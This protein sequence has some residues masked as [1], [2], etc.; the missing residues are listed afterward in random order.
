MLQVD[1]TSAAS[2]AI[3][4]WVVCMVPTVLVGFVCMALG[5]VSFADVRRR[6]SEAE[7]AEEGREERAGQRG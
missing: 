1:A 3:M 5:G 7:E 4:V 6:S 2:Y